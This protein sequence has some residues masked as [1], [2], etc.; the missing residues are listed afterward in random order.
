MLNS[1]INYPY[2]LLREM[3]EVLVKV[4]LMDLLVLRE[5]QGLQSGPHF[6]VNNDEINCFLQA[7]FAK[8]C[9]AFLQKVAIAFYRE[10]QASIANQQLLLI[11]A[12]R[13]VSGLD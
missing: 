11:F 9:R 4:R 3:P 8:S 7:L 6:S 5:D 1:N 10:L 2:P 12:S 13:I